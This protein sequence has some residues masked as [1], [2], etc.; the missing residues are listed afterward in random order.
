MSHQGSGLVNRSSTEIPLT[1]IAP[2][3]WE[4]PKDYQSGMKVP[5][6][7]YADED[8]LAKMKTDRTIQQCVNVAHLD[9][10]CNYSITMPDGHEGYGFPIGGVAATDYDE[11]L[12]SPG[13][14]GY[15]VNCISGSSLI[16]DELG[17]KRKISEFANCWRSARI[18]CLENQEA[19]GTSI[20]GFLSRPARKIL[21]VRTLLGAEILATE[22]HPFLTPEGMC[23][24]S[25][26]RR[27]KS[28]VAV[29]P[30]TGVDYEEPTEFAIVNRNDILGSPTVG[31]KRHLCKELEKRGLLPLNSTNVKLGLLLKIMGFIIGDGTLV[32][33]PKTRMSGFYGKVEDLE[34][35]RRDVLRLG[36][37]PSR[38]YTRKRESGIRT[39]YSDY[40]FTFSGSFFMAR[41]RSLISLL[42]AMG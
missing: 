36:F 17:C 35:I 25:D 39:R 18:R 42:V 6:R 1:N 15:D 27:T 16:L 40:K 2:N 19:S 7:I 23:P 29:Y 5:A 20:V 38:I 30:F 12:I 14:V 13:G 28:K 34:D 26:V 10:I 4:V 31:S 24:L 8:L 41:S 32:L 33:T 37:K 11:G 3:I 9:G 21:K 22:D